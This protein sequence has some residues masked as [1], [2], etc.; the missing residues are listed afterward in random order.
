M[1][2]AK[3]SPWLVAFEGPIAAGKTTLAELFAK[4]SGAHILLEAFGANEF[5]A[6]FYSD[7]KRWALPMQVGFLLARHQQF[8]SSVN[9][10]AP[11]VAD[12]S[13]EKDLIFS[14][15]LLSGR[16]LRLYESV[17]HALGPL[18][19]TPSLFVYL[20]ASDEILLKRIRLRNRPYEAAI[21]ATYLQRLRESYQRELLARQDIAI[22]HQDTSNIDIKSDNDIAALHDRILRSIPHA[23]G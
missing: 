12:H 15:L 11:V 19:R 1:S 3:H 8:S 7:Q 10:G 5:L 21:T 23:T 22:I 14:R 2:T 9:V 18:M 13:Y 20:D 16:E 17:R 4:A 6:D